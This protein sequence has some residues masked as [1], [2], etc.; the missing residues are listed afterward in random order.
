MLMNKRKMFNSSIPCVFYLTFGLICLLLFLQGCWSSLP[1]DHKKLAELHRSFQRLASQ[2][3]GHAG[4][5]ACLLETGQIAAIAGNEHF[6][7]QSVYK[8]PI[9]MA[10]LHEVDAGRL[11][12]DQR[13]DIKKDQLALPMYSP[14]RDTFPNGTT[15]TVRQLIQYAVSQSDNIASDELM[16]LAGGPRQVTVWL[17]S[18]GLDEIRVAATECEMFSDDKV[19]YQN[20]ATPLGA[21]KMLAVFHAGAGL[22]P[23]SH[24]ILEEDLIATSTG[25][26]RI[27]GLLPPAAQV[28]HKT[29]TSATVLGK[30]AATNDIG[31]ITLPD[32]RHLAIA[33]FI[34]D[35]AAD[36]STRQ[37]VIAQ[38][39]L[40]AYDC[41]R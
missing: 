17:K 36:I 21:I 18:L 35:S 8:M 3:Q 39:A 23:E 33:V 20:W 37:A 4:A 19:Q 32:G 15:L 13:V 25:Q 14:I 29:G 34:S 40:A 22:S 41:F 7:M 28:A 24:A 9:A 12:L 2:V 11:S 27:K 26:G 31:I 38:I 30:T 1:S 16:H 5:A 6:P 10:V